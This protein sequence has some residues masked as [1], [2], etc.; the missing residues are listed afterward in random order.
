MQI[1]TWNVNSLKVRLPQVLNWLQKTNCDVLALQEL[2]LD[3]GNFPVSA[4]SDLGYQVVYNGQKTYNG[5][6]IVSRLPI[7]D[8]CLDIPGYDDIQKRVITATI[9]NIRIMCVYVVNGESKTSEKFNYKLSWLN[10]L[11]GYVADSL[12]LY[13]NFVVLGDFNIAPDDIDVYDP[14][15]WNNQ[16]LCSI[17]ERVEW[18]K[19]IELGL[20]DSFR[21]FHVEPKQYSW[22][23]YRNFA[24]RRK[25]GLRIDHILI[26]ER[27]RQIANS[28]EIDIEPRKNDRPSDHTPV[29]LELSYLSENIIG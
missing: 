25:L 4:F 15:A 26:S 18:L 28:C 23:D 2:K 14:I 24:F 27:L 22:W 8:I 11:Y 3:N 7:E 19:L 21:L 13:D 9:N 29:V 6:A 20:Y 17:E 16:V 12:Q 1:A 10:A 5:V